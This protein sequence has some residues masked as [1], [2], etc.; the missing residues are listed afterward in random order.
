MRTD[1]RRGRLWAG[2]LRLTPA[3]VPPTRPAPGDL[4]GKL[5]V[6]LARATPAFSPGG[7]PPQAPPGLKA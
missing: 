4:K 5:L 3:F 1:S 7:A 6:G 2:L